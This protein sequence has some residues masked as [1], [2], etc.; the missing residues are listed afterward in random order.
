MD[1]LI[2]MNQCFKEAVQ[3]SDKLHLFNSKC[4]QEFGVN[5]F[6][7]IIPNGM[8]CRG[9]HPQ[10][11]PPKISIYIGGKSR[12]TRDPRFPENIWK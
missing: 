2:F 4:Y 9:L 6:C 1:G 8:D 3:L 5:I 7:Q 11:F 12:E 10:G